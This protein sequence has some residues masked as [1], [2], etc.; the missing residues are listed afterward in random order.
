VGALRERARV[1]VQ[2]QVGRARGLV[3]GGE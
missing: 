1:A 2:A 3:G